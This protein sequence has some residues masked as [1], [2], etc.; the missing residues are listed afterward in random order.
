[1]SKSLIIAEKPSVAADLARA[2]GKIPKHGDHYENDDF[3]EEDDLGWTFH[4]IRGVRSARAEHQG[5]A[6]PKVRTKTAAL[7]RDVQAGI[8]G[9]TGTRLA[10]ISECPQ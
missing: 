5:G 2:L 3:N 1:M 4:A 10:K 6:A 8:L 7:G 9:M